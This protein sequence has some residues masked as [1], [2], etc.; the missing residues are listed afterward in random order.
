MRYEEEARAIWQDFVPQSGQAQ[1]VQG[2]LMRAVEKLRDEAI[3]NGNANWDNGFA[4]LR[5][6]LERHLLDR[7][8]FDA[9]TRRATGKALWRLRFAWAPV[10]D[11]AVYDA[12][13]DRVVEYY[14][15][16][17]SKPHAPDAKLLR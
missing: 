9:E 5:R 14:R 10:M 6:Y 11:D 7:A 2:E 15:H 8:V 4:R 16:H 17:G 3:R 12:L 13:G 1:T